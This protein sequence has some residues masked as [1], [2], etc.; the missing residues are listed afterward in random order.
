MFL[1]LLILSVILLALAM[2]GMSISILVK[3]NGK[4]PVFQ[5]GHNADM[6]KMGI[7]C[8]KNEEIKCFKKQLKKKDCTGCN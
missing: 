3:K 1:N 7:S 4:F 5:I 2:L 8:V 6:R